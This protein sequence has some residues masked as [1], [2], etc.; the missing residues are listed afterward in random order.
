M[1]K[2]PKKTKTQ[3]RLAGW[4]FLGGFMH[5]TKYLVAETPAAIMV[6]V[7][8]N[9]WFQTSTQTASI[10]TGLAMF[11]ITIAISVVLIGKREEILKK[12]SPFLV[13][14]LYMIIF[15]LIAI[16]FAK[17][18]YDFG[19]LLLFTGIGM[20][21]AVVEDTTERNAVNKKIEYWSGVLADAGLND[22]DNEARAKRNA[23]VK[24]AKEEARDLI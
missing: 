7:K 16:F 10:S 18:L 3:K 17:V 23:D 2:K 8:H 12:V 4:K 22:K 9:D 5:V 11:M 14:A 15:G 21:T 24:T 1:D 13:A 19:F 20:V 6:A